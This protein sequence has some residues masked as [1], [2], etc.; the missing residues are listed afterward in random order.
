MAN[1]E[2]PVPSLVIEEFQRNRPRIESSM[3]ASVA[4]RF[5]QMRRDFDKFGGESNQEAIEVI[6]KLAYQVPL[7]GAMTTRNFDEILDLLHA[8]EN[9]EPTDGERH[10]TAHAT[11]SP[12]PY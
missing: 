6:D 5:R 3:R 8:G 2:L 11:A 10:F 9:I 12:T 1:L 4:E 7:I